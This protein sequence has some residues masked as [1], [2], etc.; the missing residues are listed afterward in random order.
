M[1][2]LVSFHPDL[3]LCGGAVE[4]KVRRVQATVQRYTMK[5]QGRVRRRRVGVLLLTH[6]HAHTHTH[7]VMEDRV[8]F[9]PAILHHRGVIQ[10]LQK[11]AVAA[12]VK[13]LWRTEKSKREER[14]E[15][16][17]GK[18]RILNYFCLNL[19]KNMRDMGR[20]CSLWFT[21]CG[22]T[23]GPLIK[24]ALQAAQLLKAITLCDYHCTL[25]SM[26]SVIYYIAAAG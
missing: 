13:P 26:H 3:S 1:S 16:G 14:N 23:L 18:R 21:T 12:R 2:L 15:V 25:S 7:L 24:S 6:A 4:A 17:E 19:V 22:N 8:E 11:L 20:P 9:L 10:V 5:D